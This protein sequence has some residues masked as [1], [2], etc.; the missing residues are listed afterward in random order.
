MPMTH[1]LGYETA[2]QK[3]VIKKIKGGEELCLVGCGTNWVEEITIEESLRSTS[4]VGNMVVKEAGDFMDKFVVTGHDETVYIEIE[5]FTIPGSD[6]K[7][8]FCINDIHKLGD[9]ATSDGRGT[10]KKIKWKVHFVSCEPMYLDIPDWQEKAGYVDEDRFLK[11]AKGRSQTG[12]GSSCTSCSFSRLEDRPEE[13]EEDLKDL[14]G[15]LADKY[16][17]PGA[18]DYSKAQNEMEIEG[19]HNGIWLKSHPNLYPWGKSTNTMSLM[20]TMTNLA[21]NAI[22][23]DMKHSNFFFWADWDGYH[24]KSVNQM[25]EDTNIPK[26][27]EGA[28]DL[29]TPH[30]YQRSDGVTQ[31]KYLTGKGDPKI[32]YQMESQGYDHI[33]HWQDGA[34]SSYYE[35]TE[36]N[37]S[38]PYVDYLDASS[39]YPSKIVDYDYHRDWEE[40]NTIEEYKI[41][42]DEIDT[43]LDKENPQK[44]RLYRHDNDIYGY[45]SPYLNDPNP[46]PYDFI[47][48]RLEQGNRGKRN[49]IYW[50]AQGDFCNYSLADLEKVHK[51]IIKPS[52]ENYK[53]FLRIKN[54]KEKWNVYRHSICCDK[55]DIK[56]QFL[57]VIDDAALISDDGGTPNRGGIYE[58]SWREV[59]IW[60]TG[61]INGYCTEGDEEPEIL[62]SDDAPLSVVVVPCGLQGKHF[63]D[64]GDNGEEPSI[65]SQWTN[66]A[67]NI[68][69]LLNTKIGDDV[70]VGPGVNVADDDFNDYPEAYQM[71]PVG[72]YFKVGD[73]PCA[74]D[75]EETIHFHK[76]V[77]QMYRLPAY[78]LECI[79]PDGSES[80]ESSSD[81]NGGEGEPE[82][83]GPEEIFFFDVP[84]AHDGLCGCI[85]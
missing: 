12:S 54:L 82:N 56:K 85:E 41:I 35:H 64:T 47:A 58:Y 53:E 18:T 15:E 6:H 81:D 33:G 75:H 67:Y 27:S 45:F 80:D 1:A 42:S 7:L 2:L 43:S 13:G 26:S 69:E 84:N 74:N 52:E 10:S 38:D 34:Y 72:G 71:M 55:Q 3:V 23:Y 9:A 14:V 59:E 36:P 8:E 78:M 22:T 51:K 37:Y 31:L 68:N 20:Q 32:L 4:V 79:G 63:M 5:N 83:L 28:P 17:N 29:T 66:G 30:V 50:Q 11:I 57:A 48:S 60:P 19:T 39:Q 49:S 73:D 44:N 40:W 16:F 21:E 65:P 70:Y 25:I 46:K 76:H 24:F 62:S 61:A 77:V